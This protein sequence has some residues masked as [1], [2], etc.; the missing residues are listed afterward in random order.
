MVAADGSWWAHHRL[1][2]TVPVQHRR[3]RQMQA[4]AGWPDRAIARA[5]GSSTAVA[6]QDLEDDRHRSLHGAV[7]AES[8]LNRIVPNAEIV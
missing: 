5:R 8:I 4:T 1:I 3:Y 2:G 7:I 6:S